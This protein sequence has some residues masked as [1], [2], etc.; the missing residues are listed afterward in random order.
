MLSAKEI[1]KIHPDWFDLASTGELTL[2]TKCIGIMWMWLRLR[3]RS[4]IF[5]ANIRCTS[6]ELY[7][8]CVWAQARSLIALNTT[9]DLEK[10]N[11]GLGCRDARKIINLWPF[12]IKILPV[13]YNMNLSH[14]I[15]ILWMYCQDFR[16]FVK[17]HFKS[18]ACQTFIFPLSVIISLIYCRVRRQTPPSVL[19]VS[20]G[21]VAGRRP[22]SQTS[23]SWSNPRPHH[24]P[25]SWPEIM[26]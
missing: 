14:Y 24:H 11:S 26:T 3:S 6:N 22:H 8:V 13:G 21:E 12:S 16:V 1:W 20:Y 10:K 25:S 19:C 2:E 23:L 4:P 7:Y 5:S 17:L 18:S 15:C 9:G